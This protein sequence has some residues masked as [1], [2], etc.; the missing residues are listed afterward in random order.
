MGQSITET[1]LQ[2]YFDNP[3]SAL[4]SHRNSAR[5]FLELLPAA[6]EI[7][8]GRVTTYLEQFLHFY[9]NKGVSMK[10][11]REILVSFEPGMLRSLTSSIQNRVVN[12]P[13][14]PGSLL[15]GTKEQKTYNL[16]FVPLQ[17]DAYDDGY[18]ETLTA[19]DDGFHTFHSISSS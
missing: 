9:R 6:G 7:R 11:A 4:E 17:F 2:T 10:L 13:G 8:G 3:S 15:M 19:R 14:P 18:S 12:I 1:G 16:P 5:E